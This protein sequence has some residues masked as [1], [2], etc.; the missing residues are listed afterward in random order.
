MQADQMYAQFERRGDVVHCATCNEL[1]IKPGVSIGPVF[2]GDGSLY[3][4]NNARSLWV[5]CS[6]GHETPVSLGSFGRIHL[7]PNAP[8]PSIPGLIAR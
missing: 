3:R 1:V 6:A 4:S 5:L 7:Q 8:D 2:A